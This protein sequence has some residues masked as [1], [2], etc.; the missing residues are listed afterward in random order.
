MVSGIIDFF[1]PIPKQKSNVGWQNNQLDEA[2]PLSKEPLVSVGMFSEYPE[3]LSFPFFFGGCGISPWKVGELK[4]ALIAPLMRKSIAEDLV[5]LNENL[6]PRYKVVIIDAYRPETVQTALF[7]QFKEKLIAPPFN[8]TEEEATKET[9]MYV[10]LPSR[11]NSPHMTGAAVD[12][13]V[14]R[15]DEKSWDEMQVLTQK[16]KELQKKNPDNF[17][18][19]EIIETEMRRNQLLRE[20]GVL[21]DMG[22]RISE[23][24]RDEKGR[25][26]TALRYFEEREEEALAGMG[27]QLTEKEREALNNRRMLF[28]A[29]AAVGLGAYAEEFWHLGKNT[30]FQ[31]PTDGS[32]P[33]YGYIEPSQQNMKH[34]LMCRK[35][36]DESVTTYKLAAEKGAR[37]LF[38]DVALAVF[39]NPE[40]RHP[41]N[42][43]SPR[44]APALPSA[45]P[46]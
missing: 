30:K 45:S 24:K 38:K 44:I 6:P 36:F 19:K 28:N 1:K 31:P 14:V 8:R 11:P 29:A 9:Q 13:A 34:E 7:E 41:N 42:P 18:V 16:V 4:G 40:Y 17:F 10:S 15:F 21:V 35:L 37:P 26:L 3:V 39:G 20:K 5:K 23:V 12:V 25:P 32:L 2:N 22:V 27:P 46:S 33:Y 43:C